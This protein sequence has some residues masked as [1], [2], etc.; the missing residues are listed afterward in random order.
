MNKDDKAYLRD[1]L[2]TARK[3]QTISTT[4]EQYENNETVQA[5]SRYWVQ[6]IGEA[7]NHV[8]LS[9]QQENP[10]I[11]WRAMIGMRNRIVHDYLG[12][13]NDIVWEVM[14][15]NTV[16]LIEQLEVLLSE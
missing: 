5:A 2:T 3:L 12:I 14:T 8:S 10:H 6:I 15:R 13:D 11:A 1:M 9:F 7:A 16:V 4:R